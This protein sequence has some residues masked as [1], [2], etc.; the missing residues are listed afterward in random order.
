MGVVGGRGGG[1]GN[2]DSK[3]M[4]VAGSTATVT[5]AVDLTDEIA[6]STTKATRWRSGQIKLAAMNNLPFTVM[7]LGKVDDGQDTIVCTGYAGSTV[8]VVHELL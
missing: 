3:W 7:L 5:A 4:V 2:G 1:G 8:T 6:E